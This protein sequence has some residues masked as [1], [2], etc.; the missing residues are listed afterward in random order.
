MKITKTYNHKNGYFNFDTEC[1]HCG[2]IKTGYE[3]FDDGNQHKVVSTLKC[4][5]CGKSGVAE[6]RELFAPAIELIEKLA[7]NLNK[8]TNTENG[9]T[10]QDIHRTGYK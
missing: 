1:K 9:S 2:D 5:K 4:E 8:T 7:E 3:G 10:K 6:N